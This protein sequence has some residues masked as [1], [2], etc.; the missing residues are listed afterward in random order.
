M[1]T[2]IRRRRVLW[3]K[4]VSIRHVARITL[5]VGI[6][7]ERVWFIHKSFKGVKRREIAQAWV[8]VT[9]AVIRQTIGIDLFTCIA[10]ATDKTTSCIK[11]QAIRAVSLGSLNL[12]SVG[13]LHP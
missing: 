6:A 12:E 7:V 13:H 4:P 9:G 1:S 2:K 10:K 8:I 5:P 11:R 3:T